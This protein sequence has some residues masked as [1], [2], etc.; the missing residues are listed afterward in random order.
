MNDIIWKRMIYHGQD[1]GDYYLISNSGDIKSVKTGKIR[2]KNINHEGYYFVCVSLGSRQNKPLIKVHRAVAETF[3][4]NIYDLS[5]I[6][7]KD[8]NKLN[9]HVD[10]LEF[11]THQHNVQHAYDTGLAKRTSK[12][13]I[14]LNNNM[15]FGSICDA[16]IWA[17]LP[18]NSSSISDLLCGR[19]HRK[20]AG[21][22][23]NTNEPLE[24]MYYS[25]YLTLN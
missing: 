14:C 12:P 17:G 10:N 16:N 1:I 4:D 6:N 15:V 8:G 7:H 2:K 13:V 23:R 18:Y 5:D 11:C 19:D 24:W 3:L 21:V 25:E 20:T 22:D 9:N